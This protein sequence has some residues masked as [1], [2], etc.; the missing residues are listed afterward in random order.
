MQAPKGLARLD[1]LMQRWI[2]RT[3][4]VEVA[5]GC[6]YTSGAFE[7][8]DRDGELRET[9]LSEVTRW[10]AALRR[11]VQMAI[12]TGELRADAD[13]MQLVSELNALVMGLL[14]DARFLRD[15]Q[16]SDRA[17]DTW[18]RLRTSY[19]APVSPSQPA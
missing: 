19:R 8:D 7:L 4:D 14:H 18:Q 17:S 16:A 12:D 15:P 10:R 9:L 5:T 2:A 11:T 6:L 13:P 1:S 3:R